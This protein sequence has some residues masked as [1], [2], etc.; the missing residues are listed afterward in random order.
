MTNFR[1]FE[2][3]RVAKR[4]CCCRAGAA[5]AELARALGL[6]TSLEGAAVGSAKRA[7]LRPE[8]RARAL[9]RPSLAAPVA[10]ARLRHSIR[11][12][13]AVSAPVA[14]AQSWRTHTSTRP[15]RSRR[16]RPVDADADV[17]AVRHAVPCA[18]A[19]AAVSLV[20]SPCRQFRSAVARPDMVRRPGRRRHRGQPVLVL[21]FYTTP[22][23][24]NADCSMYSIF[25]CSTVPRVLD[26]A[27]EVYYD[28][29]Y[30][31]R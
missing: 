24:A 19:L 31:R 18:G 26:I 9:P 28:D 12:L 2:I 16:R 23:N 3:G 4:K 17:Y 29:D 6:R 15:S 8:C 27:R 30:H 22:Y 14:P 1:N 11:D 13:L 5:G 7:R 21:Y 20:P 10:V 25:G